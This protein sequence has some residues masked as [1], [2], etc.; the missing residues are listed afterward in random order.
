[1]YGRTDMPAVLTD[2]EFKVLAS[3]VHPHTDENRVAAILAKR[4]P[5]PSQDF[6]RGLTGDSALPCIQVPPQPRIG[7]SQGRWC[8]PVHQEGNDYFFWLLDTNTGGGADSLA[9]AAQLTQAMS[10][11][12][13]FPA[14]QGAKRRG[15]ELVECFSEDPATADMAMSVV[16][17]NHTVAV[18][19]VV[20]GPTASLDAIGRAWEWC[21][22]LEN[23]RFAPTQ[24]GL[25]A[26]A[27]EGDLPRLVATVESNGQN[28]DVGVGAARLTDRPSESLDR[29]HFMSLVARL[30]ES[31]TVMFWERSGPW[32]AL[33][34]L[35]LGWT[36]L[37]LLGPGLR[38]IIEEKPTL[39]HTALVYLEAPNVDAAVRE[40]HI[41]R[42]TLYY[43]LGLVNSYL[44]DGWDSGWSRIGF[45]QGLR[46]GR[47]LTVTEEIVQLD[48][49]QPAE[50]GSVF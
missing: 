19:V 30:P 32:T 39:A 45:H 16:D 24:A 21:P 42:N 35:P 43:R 47:L 27:P 41:H 17:F 37:D 2:R 26:L 14:Q 10:H 49:T 36:T 28:I 5:T 6:V 48:V 22:A 46:L 31:S 9:A 23:V 13:A 44:G 50:S 8:L 40:L 11:H 20:A 1:L 3:S 18:A 12:G 38:A 33:S 29:A 7:M 4:T 34:H 15:L 25:L